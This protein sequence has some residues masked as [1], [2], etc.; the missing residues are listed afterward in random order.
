MTSYLSTKNCRLLLS[1][2][3]TLKSPRRAA[4]KTIMELL[5]EASK[6]KGS[7]GRI[8][9]VR[10]TTAVEVP[11]PAHFTRKM[12]RKKSVL[13]YFYDAADIVAPLQSRIIT[14]MRRTSPVP[15]SA[16]SAASAVSAVSAVPV[17][18][19][20]VPVSAVPA[21]VSAPVPVPVSVPVSAAPVSTPTYEIINTMV[22]NKQI[23]NIVKCLNTGNVKLVHTG[24]FI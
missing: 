18:V 9:L 23:V 24:K 21:P 15:V 17:S 3:R 19:S 20:A 22:K 13:D 12:N 4:R 6:K 5:F 8:Q 11:A 14:I 2:Q 16:A 10:N 1:R 7:G